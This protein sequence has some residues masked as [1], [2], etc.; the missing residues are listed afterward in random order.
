MSG[1]GDGRQIFAYREH[2][3]SIGS[4]ND[5][6]LALAAR[7]RLPLPALVT[8]TEQTRGRGRHGKRWNSHTGSVT[9]TV[10]IGLPGADAV[11]LSRAAVGTA[12]CLVDAVARL[13]PA[14]ADSLHLKWPNDVFLGGGKLAGVLVE[15]RRCGGDLRLAVGY[16]LNVTDEVPAGAATLA[17]YM[18]TGDQNAPI[19]AEVAAETAAEIASRLPAIARDGLPLDRLAELDLLA[20][21]QVVVRNAP[22]GEVTA[23]GRAVAIDADGRFLIDTDGRVRGVSSGTVEYAEDSA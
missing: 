22:G 14:A 20:G 9:A 7:P 1:D 18:P 12:V 15:T 16:G 21:R 13:T 23:A 2:H 17:R 3:A 6:A 5:R 8:A 10:V 19:A 4:T 11:T